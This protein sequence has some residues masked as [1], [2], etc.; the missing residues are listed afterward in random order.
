MKKK[1]PWL[2]VISPRCGTLR[3]IDFFPL[4]YTSGVFAID[5]WHRVRFLGD[6][7]TK[8]RNWKVCKFLQVIIYT[9][10]WSNY[11]DLTRPGPPNGGL[12]REIPLFQGNLGW[13]NIIPFGQIYIYIY[14]SFGF[15]RR[16]FL[17]LV[18][19]CKCQLRWCLKATKN[20]GIMNHGK[21][22]KKKLRDGVKMWSEIS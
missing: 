16:F 19:V 10:I 12:V 20:H 22:T 9:Y 21:N 15:W 4:L 6:R 1:V 7:N 13:W 11:S 5:L 2:A 17:L 8:E 18:G 3:P 14:I